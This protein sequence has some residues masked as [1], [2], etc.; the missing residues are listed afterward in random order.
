MNA[1]WDAEASVWVAT[2]DDVPGLAT[3]SAS[4]EVLL[5]KLR[6]MVPELLE[7]NDAQR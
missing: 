6:T 5:E 3:E 2:S 4:F 7:L 1:L